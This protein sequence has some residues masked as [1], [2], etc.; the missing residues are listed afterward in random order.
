LGIEKLDIG[1]IRMDEK[2]KNPSGFK[3]GGRRN[4]YRTF[5]SVR[6]WILET[7]MIFIE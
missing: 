5:D 6:G 3:Q 7:Y 4:P 2:G 1:T